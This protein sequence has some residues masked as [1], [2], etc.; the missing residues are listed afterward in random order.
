MD[1]MVGIFLAVLIAR[2]LLFTLLL[3]F[4]A[5]AAG[6]AAAGTTGGVLGAIIGAV[7]GFGLDRLLT[8][9]YGVGRHPAAS[10]LGARRWCC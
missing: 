4:L 10:R 2:G 8:C 6:Y 1:D 5:S 3:F 9:G 7:I